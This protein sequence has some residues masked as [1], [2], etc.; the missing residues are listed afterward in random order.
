[1]F[2]HVLARFRPETDLFVFSNLS[3]DTLDYTSGTVNRGSKA[4]LLGL[5]E[6]VRGLP[7]EFRGDLPGGV[8]RAEVF[9]AGCLVVEATAF[10]EE[11]GLAARLAREGVF[12]DW[13]LVVVHDDASVARNAS[14]FLWATWTRFEPASDIHAAATELRRHHVTY[15]APVEGRWRLNP[16]RPGRAASSSGAGRP[17]SCPRCCSRARSCGSRSSKLTTTSTAT[18]AATRS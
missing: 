7:R 18:S 14:D 3:M 10:R 6:A 17:A 4:V 16:F 13:P 9:C 12:R 2:E 8:T 15:T 1:L 5:G 11:P